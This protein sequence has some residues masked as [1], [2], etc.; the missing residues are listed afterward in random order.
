MTNTVVLQL[1]SSGD[2][3]SLAKW[4]N[5]DQVNPYF[6]KANE[7]KTHQAVLEFLKGLQKCD[8]II[9]PWHLNHRSYLDHN[10]IKGG[11]HQCP[12]DKMISF[13][14]MRIKVK[15][16]TPHAIFD[17][18]GKMLHRSFDYLTIGTAVPFLG[19]IPGVMRMVIGLSQ[20]VG[21]IALAIIFALPA[22]I[23]KSE[24][25]QI[26]MDRACQHILYGPRN[27]GM[28]ALQGTPILG[29]WIYK[30]TLA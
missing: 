14:E 8:E 27:I 12:I 22:Y 11:Q 7:C 4:Q 17:K 21:G 30:G 29:T 28:G 16:S 26:V 10:N 2:S 9:V 18:I 19:I 20:L 6:R 25:A 5:L 24:N 1:S 23:Y 13:V 15:N 3:L